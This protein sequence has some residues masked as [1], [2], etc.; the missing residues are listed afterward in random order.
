MFLSFLQI[1][2]FMEIKQ[3]AKVKRNI[4]KKETDR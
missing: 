2:V 4:I 1:D 3:A